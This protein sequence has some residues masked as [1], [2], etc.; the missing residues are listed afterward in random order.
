MEKI[1]T[2][3]FKSVQTTPHPIIFYLWW[4]SPVPWGIHS[5]IASEPTKFMYES[6]GHEPLKGA[7]LSCSSRPL[8][9]HP[10]M[11]ATVSSEKGAYNPVAHFST[12]S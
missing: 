6:E 7:I 11:L 9:Q 8:A 12:S 5:G 2:F 4:L 3:S 10:V 1:L